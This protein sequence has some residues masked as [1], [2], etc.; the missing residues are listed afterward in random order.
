MKIQKV[1]VRE[2]QKQ[3]LKVQNAKEKTKPRQLIV[4]L[5][6]NSVESQKKSH[7]REW[8]SLRNNL[9]PKTIVLLWQCVPF[10]LQVQKDLRHTKKV[11]EVQETL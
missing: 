5:G 7:E 1:K 10:L 11:M 3:V 6:Q 4:G 9:D 2:V 8:G